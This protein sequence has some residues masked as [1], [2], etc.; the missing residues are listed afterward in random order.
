MLKKIFML[1]LTACRVDETD[2]LPDTCSLSMYSEDM[3]T[4]SF[5][6]MTLCVILLQTHYTFEIIVRK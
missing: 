4:L 1:V 6:S 3:D 2:V 5:R